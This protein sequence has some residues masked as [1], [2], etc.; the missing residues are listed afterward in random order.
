L[1]SWVGVKTEISSQERSQVAHARRISGLSN[2]WL[3]IPGKLSGTAACAA[4]LSRK[5]LRYLIDEPIAWHI[6]EMLS[7]AHVTV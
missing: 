7:A 2:G 4:S 6:Y 3:C 5:L 1:L